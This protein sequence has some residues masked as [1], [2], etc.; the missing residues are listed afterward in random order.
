MDA[1]CGR[2]ARGNLPAQASLIFERRSWGAEAEQGLALALGEWAQAIRDGV[3]AGRMELWQ[4]DGASW[5]VTE[6]RDGVLIVWCYQGRDV[7]RV[8]EIFRRSLVRNGLDT[9][10]FSTKRKGLHRLLAPLG[11]ELVAVDDGQFRRYQVDA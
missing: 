5:A 4:I 8:A 11:F 9:L 1:D 10:E 6:I 7:V 2:G 3:T